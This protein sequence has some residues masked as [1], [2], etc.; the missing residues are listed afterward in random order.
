MFLSVHGPAAP[1]LRRSVIS[2]KKGIAGL[3]FWRGKPY[4]AVDARSDKQF[5][6]GMDALSSYTTI[7]MM[8]LP[9]RSAGKVIGVMQFLNKSGN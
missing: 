2:I 9:I 3:V 1:K 4:L 6:K 5:F 7:D 8:C